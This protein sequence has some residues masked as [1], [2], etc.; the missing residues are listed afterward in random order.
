MSQECWSKR[1]T[2][3]HSPF[4]SHIIGNPGKVGTDPRNHSGNN[5]SNPWIKRPKNVGGN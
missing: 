5:L 1:Q 4:N 2:I 3:N